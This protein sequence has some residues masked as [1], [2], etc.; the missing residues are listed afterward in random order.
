MVPLSVGPTVMLSYYR[1]MVIYF[2]VHQSKFWLCCSKYSWWFLSVYSSWQM[3]ES[4]VMWGEKKIKPSLGLLNS[5]PTWQA[6]SHSRPAPSMP[7]Q[8][9]KRGVIFEGQAT[10]LMAA[11]PYRQKAY[12]PIF[13]NQE[14]KTIH[15]LVSGPLIKL[16]LSVQFSRS[17][18]SDSLQP[19]E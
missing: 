17:A 2:H 11:F 8:G 3:L 6:H 15:S 1:V 13:F 9:F 19:H 5:Q 7:L 10:K 14:I 16:L 12:F 4:L 18:V